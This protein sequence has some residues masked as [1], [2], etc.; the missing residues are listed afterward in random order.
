MSLAA[1]GA[2]AIADTASVTIQGKKKAGVTW[3]Q[4]PRPRCGVVWPYRDLESFSSD[5]LAELR[6]C[7]V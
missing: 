5:R 6:F 4:V 3:S 2:P 1:R 7:N